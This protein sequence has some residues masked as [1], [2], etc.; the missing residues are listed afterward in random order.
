M[1][2]LAASPAVRGELV[3]DISAVNL[4]VPSRAE[5]QLRAARQRGLETVLVKMSGTTEVLEAPPI[6]AALD[7]P[8]RFLTQYRYE[9]RPDGQ[10]LDLRLEYDAE[11]LRRLLRD[12]GA[13]LWTANRPVVLAWLV[14]SE[15]ALR[16]FAS[17]ADYP[18]L[19][20]AMREAFARRGLP[21]RQ[22]LY[23]LEDRIH[24]PVGAAW[25]QDAATLVSASARY[26]DTLPLAGRVARLADGRWVGDWRFLDDG[27]WV[28]RSVT[29]ESPA[30]FAAQAADLVAATL[31]ARYA[32]VASGDGDLRLQLTVSGIR[33][34]QALY[35]LRLALEALESV[36]RVVPERV[37]ADEVILRVESAAEPAAL[38]RILELDGRFLPLAVPAGESLSYRWGGDP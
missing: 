7:T 16:R 15:E 4:P 37:T 23:D 35:R 12:A 1:L 28:S 22:P 13:P 5:A 20:T 19:R 17:D 8:E 24:L 33:S 25:R 11:A 14:V 34:Y 10:G 2:L 27:R 3:E 31:T 30:P 29:A 26:R 21:L 6:R 18:E 32:V 9:D 36:D 38:A